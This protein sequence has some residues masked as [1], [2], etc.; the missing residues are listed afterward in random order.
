VPSYEKENHERKDE[1]MKPTTTTLVSV[2]GIA[3]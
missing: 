3:P 1:L 2:T